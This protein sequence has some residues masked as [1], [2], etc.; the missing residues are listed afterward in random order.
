MDSGD[1]LKGI[2]TAVFESFGKDFAIYTE[3][4]KQGFKKPCF[5]IGLSE[6]NA[7]KLLGNRL[8]FRNAF[9]IKL[10]DD[11]FEKKA[12]DFEKKL[13]DALEYIF[14]E[15]DILHGTNQ[16]GVFKDGV[17]HFYVEYN[18]FALR[19]KEKDQLMEV[20]DIN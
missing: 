7:S 16:K 20:L 19:Q 8:F 10:Y 5:F 13:F 9:Y 2:C 4:V 11:F 3:N 12:V 1:I 17:Y 6:Q 18:F 14:A 15:N